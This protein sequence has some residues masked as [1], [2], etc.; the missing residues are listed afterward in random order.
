[1]FPCEMARYIAGFPAEARKSDPLRWSSSRSYPGLRS[2]ET[3]LSISEHAAGISWPLPAP[4]VAAA[5][6]DGVVAAD[7][8]LEAPGA[9]GPD[10]V[11]EA[12]GAAAGPLERVAAPVLLCAAPDV[13]AAVVK[14][15]VGVRRG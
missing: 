9:A 1:M 15:G 8:R 6:P 14:P 7:A 12:P 4:P 10:A 5:E 13:A 3:R 11:A 2:D